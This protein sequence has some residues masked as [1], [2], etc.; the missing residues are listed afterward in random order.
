MAG[1]KIPIEVPEPG[2]TKMKMTSK[3]K[4]MKLNA[5]IHKTVMTA[6]GGLASDRAHGG[7][8][9]EESSGPPDASRAQKILVVD[10]DE[11]IRLLISSVLTAAGFEVKVVS[12]GEQAWEG[13]LH[14]RY[15]LLVTDLEMPR[16]PGMRLIEQIREAGMSLPVIIASGSFSLERVFSCP[17][18]QIAAVIPKPFDILELLDTV[19]QVLR[20]ACG[21]A[22]AEDQTFH[23]LHSSAHG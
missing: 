2:E 19:R 7:S 1:A 12:D 17:Q 10:D 16:L 22:A 6:V 4:D 18:L 21:G 5:H 9:V 3:S 8:C 14:E 20:R 11:D 13:L 23:Q 15:D